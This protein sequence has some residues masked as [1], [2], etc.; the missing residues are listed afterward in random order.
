M[1][2]D[3][4]QKKLITA[5]KKEAPSNQVPYAF[6]KRIMARIGRAAPLS[7]WALWARPLWSAAA[8]CMAI[9]ALC[10]IWFLTARLHAD[11]SDS[12]SQDFERTV[13]SSFNQRLE[14][15]W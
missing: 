11:N 4:L 8:S 5:A 6:E 15:S 13:F 7:C 2:L 3:Q 14:D 9:T 12:F 1:Q 10:G